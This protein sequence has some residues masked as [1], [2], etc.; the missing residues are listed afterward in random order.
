MENPL[1][2]LDRVENAAQALFKL[3]LKNCP[4]GVLTAGGAKDIL[5][6]NKG[7]VYAGL[8]TGTPEAQAAL[9]E[10]IDACEAI[11]DIDLCI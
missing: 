4:H 10:F 7:E 5:E 3:G 9:R 8:N 11:G 1:A 6:A 2:T